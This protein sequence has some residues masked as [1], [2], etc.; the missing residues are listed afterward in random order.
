MKKNITSVLNI[1]FYW[2]ILYTLVWFFINV[3]EKKYKETTLFSFVK[4]FIKFFIIF[5]ASMI[6]MNVREKHRIFL[7]IKSSDITYCERHTTKSYLG[8]NFFFAQH[9]KSNVVGWLY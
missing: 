4:L 9:T 6:K 8:T 1:L 7:H 3:F 5:A 2:H